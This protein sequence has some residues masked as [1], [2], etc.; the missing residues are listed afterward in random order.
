MTNRMERVN[1]SIKRELS[2][3]I[4]RELT[5]TNI[6]GLITVNKVDTAPDFSNSKVY[7]TMI[8]VKNK[9]EAMLALKK[10][11]GFMRTRLAH[12]LQ[13]RKMPSLIFIYDESVEYGSRINEI[14]HDLHKDLKSKN[15]NNHNTDINEDEEE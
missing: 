6:T 7:V 10:A 8:A 5:N 13:F 4:S 12:T 2:N 15:D 3:I 1:S 9:K 14:I 11:S